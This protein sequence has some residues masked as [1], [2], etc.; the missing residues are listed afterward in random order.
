MLAAI[1]LIVIGIPLIDFLVHA[2][3]NAMPGRPSA[4]KSGGL[5]P[6][7]LV[8][9]QDNRWSTSK[10]V[11]LA[12]NGSV[13]AALLSFAAASW[14]G[15]PQA[16]SHLTSEG[17]NGQYTV[18][19]G[20]PLGSAIFAKGIVSAQ[21][22]KG[23]TVKPPASAASPSQLWQNDAGEADLGDAQYLL[24]NLVAFVFFYGAL[25]RAPQ[26]GMPVIPSI[27]VGLTSL[28]AVGYLGN[29]SLPQPAPAAV[30]SVSPP[31]GS[32]ADQGIG[33]AGSAAAAART[34]DSP[35]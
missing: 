35:P 6:W 26:A 27:L 29:K 28:S 31:G 4:Q 22:K 3:L 8:L 23:T 17:L 21:I 15:Y 18:L 16:L 1:G 12:W 11:L 13:A 25:W 2:L 9:G 33:T 34:I 5:L 32:G 20:A 7:A 10:T 19:I 14:F 24:F 30:A